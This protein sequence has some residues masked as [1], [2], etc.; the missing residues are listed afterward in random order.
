MRV[1]KPR[2]AGPAKIGAEQSH[3]AGL[4]EGMMALLTATESFAHS[5]LS[6]EHYCLH[7]A[8][9]DTEIREVK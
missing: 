4:S 7:S 5:T 9:E 2:Y 8:D 6:S 1:S 3:A